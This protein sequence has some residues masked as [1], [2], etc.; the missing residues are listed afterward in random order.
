MDQ[1]LRIASYA[2]GAG[3]TYPPS[4]FNYYSTHYYKNNPSIPQVP[5]SMSQRVV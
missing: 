5:G 2:A 4:Y 1:Q 3:I